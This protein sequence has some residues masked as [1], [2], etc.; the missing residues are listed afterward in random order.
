MPHSTRKKKQQSSQKLINVSSADGWTVVGRKSDAQRPHSKA[1][2]DPEQQRDRFK[3]VPPEQLLERLTLDQIEILSEND[4]VASRTPIVRP[5]EITQAEA[6][7]RYNAVASSWLATKAR[8]RALA[9]IEVRLESH[10]TDVTR[11]AVCFGLGSLSSSPLIA[12]RNALWQLAVFQ[13]IVDILQKNQLQEQPIAKYAQDP[14][15]NDVDHAVLTSLDITVLETPSAFG[16]ID[17]HTFAYAPH[18]PIAYWPAQMR[19]GRVGPVLG[20]DVE[21]GL[22]KFVNTDRC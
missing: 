1:A 3:N 13:D 19:Q 6:R 12:S 5:A 22:P 2:S 21:H 15:F 16:L 20:N 8:S 9:D 7:E 18:Y 14:V 11:K 4:A 10:S 17:E